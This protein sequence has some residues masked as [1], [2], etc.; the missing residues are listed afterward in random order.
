MAL[1]ELKFLLFS[2][3]ITSTISFYSQLWS[4]VQLGN[5][6]L[7]KD[8][9]AKNFQIGSKT[10]CAAFCEKEYFCNIWCH[11]GF[12]ICTL[13]SAFVSPN[14][15]EKSKDFSN[16]YTRKR[17]DIAYLALTNSSELYEEDAEGNNSVD[18][19]YLEGLGNEFKSKHLNKPWIL[20]DLGKT[21]RIFKIIMISWK[22]SCSR[23][24]FRVGDSLINEDY[25]SS[26]VRYNS[27]NSICEEGKTMSLTPLTEMRGQYV[28]VLRNF[29][30][31][32]RERV[33]I[34]I[35]HI[36]IDGAFEE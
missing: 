12:Q 10:F 34:Q 24:E 2:I 27:T 19:I 14:Y 21:A 15:V 7:E 29:G 23:Y 36:E 20:F 31:T 16:C 26:F 30:Y 5:F 22:S 4:Q 28:A 11:D 35:D 18:G 33:A 32:D 17:R 8:T 1:F 9:L 25:F 13:S 3:Q 6:Y